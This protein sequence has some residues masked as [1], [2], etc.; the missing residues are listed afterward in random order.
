MILTFARIDKPKT[1]IN[2]YLRTLGGIVDDVRTRIW[3]QEGNIYIPDL[4]HT[5]SDLLY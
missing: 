4:S 3:K 2:Q 5:V 1:Y